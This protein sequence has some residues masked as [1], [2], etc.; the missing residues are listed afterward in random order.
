MSLPLQGIRVLDLSRLLPGAY[1]SQMLA[2]YG[3]DVIKV[4]E[5]RTGDYARTMPPTDQNGINLYFQAINRNKR[6]MTLNLKTESGRALFLRL[7]ERADVV[8]ESFRPGVMARLGLAYER[9]RAVRPELIYCAISGYGQDGPYSERAGH[10]LNYAGYAGLLHHL[11]DQEGRPMM[12]PT[13][14]GDLVG[15]SYLAVIGILTA[16]LGRQQTGEGRMVDVA[17]TEG[18]LSL[19][20]LQIAAYLHTGK[21]PLPG[22]TSLTGDLPCYHIYETK[23]GQ[24]LTLG[25][26]EPKFWHAFCTRIGHLEL[27]PFHSPVGPDEREQ[28][29]TILRNV[30]K[31]KTRDEWMAELGDLDSCVGPVYTLAEA[32]NDPQ[33]QARGVLF[34]EAENA[35]PQLSTFPR[36]SDVPQTMRSKP[37]ALGE[38]TSAILQEYGFQVEAIEQFRKEGVI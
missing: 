28:A 33:M 3:A 13:Q 37:P 10:D 36:L 29:L 19:L 14:F 27:L 32:L 7:V 30:F 11:R 12:P 17:M 31:T 25:A 4:E 16:L 26:L 38:H 2:D 20:P 18:L 1:A 21:E 5:P 6:S 15:G 22:R 23:D 24:F 35:P 34:R 9:L 8:L